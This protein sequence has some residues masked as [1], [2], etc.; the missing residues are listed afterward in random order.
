MCGFGGYFALNGTTTTKMA[1]Q[2]AASMTHRGP[3]SEG[4]HSEGPIALAFRRLAILDP[5]PAGHQPMANAVESVWIVF[6]GEIYNYRELRDRVSGYDFNSE[7]DT[8]VLLHLYEEYGI[9]CLSMLRGMY[10]F[11]IWDA[12][13]EQLF[14]ARDRL[15]QKPLFYHRDDTAFRFGS[16]IRTLLADPE[17]EARPDA[18]AIRSFLTY[19]YVPIPKTGFEDIYRVRP[20]EYLVVTEDGIQRDSYWELSYSDQ[21]D[22]GPTQIAS[23]LREKLR[24]ATRLRM[25]SDVPLGVFLSGGLDSTIVTGLM[26]E[27]AET[28]INTYSIGFEEYDELEF[29]RAVADEYDTNHHEHTVTPDAMEVLPEI[30]EHYEMPFGDPSAVPTYYV[31]K[32]A[33]KDITVAVGGDAGDENFAGYDRYTYDRFTEIAAGL[34]EPVRKPFKRGLNTVPNIVPG[35]STA[36]RGARLLENTERDTIEQYAQYICHMLGEDAQQVW[37]GSEP[38][39]EIAYIR[40]A[41]A[42]SDGPTRLDRILNTDIETYLPDD[43]LVKLDRASMAHSMEARSPF[44]DHELVEFAAKIPAKYKWRHG[45]KKSIL[46]QAFRKYIPETVQGRSKQGFSVPVDSWFRGELRD[47]ARE[48][49]ERLGDRQL[50]DSTNL[51]KKLNAHLTGNTNCGHHLWDLVVLEMWYERFVN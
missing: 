17:V 41:F 46:K 37:T 4:I 42:D 18:D 32:I 15:G 39:D 10:A 19:Q 23:R 3:D 6:N 24:E 11:A 16:T 38:D 51:E 47:L 22:A 33:S 21:F 12:K 14:L 27:Q 2:M 36:S 50:F 13:R 31:S 7:T 20:G 28:P 30:V 26:A 34:P 49:I 5:T 45:K 35:A 8:E 43:L 25:R 29:A 1:E 44:L 9:E 40:A 48:K